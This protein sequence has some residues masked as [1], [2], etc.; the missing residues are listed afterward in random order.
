[1]QLY[2]F[3]LITFIL[4]THNQS[5][6][7][8]EQESISIIQVCDLSS[9]MLPHMYITQEQVE[10]T[11][12]EIKKRGGGTLSFLFTLDTRVA[13][14][15]LRIPN[16]SLNSSSRSALNKVSQQSKAAFRKQDFEKEKKRFLEQINLYINT[17]YESTP[18][19]KALQITTRMLR[20]SFDKK[21]V[22]ILSDGYDS[23][24]PNNCVIT[25]LDKADQIGVIGWENDACLPAE[26][27]SYYF[28]FATAFNDIFSQN[29]N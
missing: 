9:S 18:L 28:D 2:K 23:F 3:L 16:F 12:N 7:A 25:Q 29:D 1:M 4:F 22:L 20:E 6:Q 19:E 8:Q 24:S 21:I 5:I 15:R 10:S 13:P 11:I 17:R 14:L 27:P 26:S